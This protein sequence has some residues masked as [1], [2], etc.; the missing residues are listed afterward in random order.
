ML[1]ILNKPN[2]KLS[3]TVQPTFGLEGHYTLGALDPTD[4]FYIHYIPKN[5]SSYIRSIISHDNWKELTSLEYLVTRRYPRESLCFI[6]DPYQRW[7]SGITEFLFEAFRDMS[8][9]E[10]YW[11]PIVRILT[12]NPVMDS[13]TEC[14]ARFLERMDLQQFKF[15]YIK[16]FET[17]KNSL[18]NWATTHNVSFSGIESVTLANSASEHPKKKQINDFLK[19]ILSNNKNI[20][21]TIK[22]YYSVDYELIE[23][24]GENYKWIQ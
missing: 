11:E 23:W 1:K 22:D 10:N 20:E 18:K 2:V 21:Q 16:D 4:M 7:I 12:L 17:T 6:R 9:I 14:Q 15:I 5:A 3:S 13:H 19:T 24:I 8:S